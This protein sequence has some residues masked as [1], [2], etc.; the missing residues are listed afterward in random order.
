MMMTTN[1]T[2]ELTFDSDTVTSVDVINR[3]K[4]LI[5][6]D[7]LHFRW[8]KDEVPGESMWSDWNE[9]LGEAVSKWEDQKREGHSS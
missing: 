3:I 5:K 8:E 9:T 1:V 7:S 2:I 4:E 6:S